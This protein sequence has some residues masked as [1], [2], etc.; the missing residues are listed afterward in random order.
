MHLPVLK[1]Y[2]KLGMDAG[3]NS[4]KSRIREWEQGSIFVSNGSENLVFPGFSI[5]EFLH[6]KNR[7]KVLFAIFPHHLHVMPQD[8]VCTLY[9]LFVKLS[10]K[11]VLMVIDLL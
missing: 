5:A 3:L 11:P 8:V 9:S 6:L 4:K 10:C 1:F 2:V 7:K